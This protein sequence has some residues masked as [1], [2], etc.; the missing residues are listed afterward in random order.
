MKIKLFFAYVFEFLRDGFY[1][2]IFLFLPFITKEIHLTLFQAGS[3][4]TV[5]N[6]LIVILAIPTV[7]FLIRFG[8]I[9]MLLF[10]LLLYVVAFLGLSIAHSYWFLL[11]IYC[12]IGVS[13]GF[14]ATISAHITTTWFSK[15]NRGEETGK[16]MAVGD[17]SKVIFSIGIGFFAGIIGWRVTSLGIGFL[18]GIIFLFFCLL[19]SRKSSSSKKEEKKLENITHASYKFLIKQKQLVLSLITSSLD[20]GINAPFYAF[21]PFLL[22]YK[23]VSLQFI[24]YVV[25]FYYV[26]NVISRLV[27]GKLVDTIGSAQV[28]ILLELTMALFIFFLT[29]S[30]S[31][32]LVSIF[33]LLLGFVTE[34]TDPAT[35][36]MT[37]EAIEAIPNAQRSSGMRSL[38]NGV[39]KTIF[40]LILGFVA[41]K[42][43]ILWGF[44]FLAFASLLPIIPA[45]VFLKNKTTLNNPLKEIQNQVIA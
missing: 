23:G 3:L 25:G 15:E 5:V 12:F 26:G 22:L 28:L 14:Y 29:V 19:I 11:L 18:T 39:G 1:L 38:S 16:L 34:G 43:G 17:I 8:E 44:Y 35:V 42:W 30:S 2:G 33:A 6:L 24:G 13:F 4:Q 7:W 21:L 9:Q 41:N 45:W 36:A 20:Q 37:A 31:I 40:P 27:F 10:S 32:I